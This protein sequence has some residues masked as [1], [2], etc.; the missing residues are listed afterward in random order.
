VIEA[1]DAVVALDQPIAWY[2]DENW[3]EFS[4]GPLLQMHRSGIP[5]CVKDS[6][7]LA[8]DALWFFTPDMQCS[9]EPPIMV[10]ALPGPGEE[11]NSCIIYSWDPSVR[12]QEQG[13][14]SFHLV[15]SRSTDACHD[16]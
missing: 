10:R 14:F 15:S 4:A 1:V 2:L 12:E 7:G 5:F 13:A 9:G 3:L 6:G 8:E 16:K 11:G